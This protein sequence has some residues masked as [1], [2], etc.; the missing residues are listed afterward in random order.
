MRRPNLRATRPGRVH[1]ATRLVCAYAA[2]AVPPPT[3]CVGLCRIADAARKKATRQR[4]AGSAPQL[5]WP[6]CHW[7]VRSPHP[8]FR[9][10]GKPAFCRGWEIKITAP[11]WG[12]SRM[13]GQWPS[14]PRRVGVLG[15][16]SCL[17]GWLVAGTPRHL[18]TVW[19]HSSHYCTSDSACLRT[20]LVHSDTIPAL[21]LAVVNLHG[22]VVYRRAL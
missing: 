19:A 4:E 9:R 20:L 18:W 21:N 3:A 22:S 14:S 11:G 10:L 17:G 15:S 2:F 13:M 5:A 12:A 7:I 6:L 16:A 1:S 8:V